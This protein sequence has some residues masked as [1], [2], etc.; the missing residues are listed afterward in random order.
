MTTRPS[1]MSSSGREPRNQ[2]VGGDSETLDRADEATATAEAT[3]AV[4]LR[5]P[6]RQDGSVMWRVARE[7]GVLEEN[8]EYV[9]N[10]FCHF[11]ARACVV[12]EVDG[13][14]AGFIAGLFPPEQPDTVFVWQI[15]VDERFRGRRIARL[16]LAELLRRN[17]PEIRFLEATVTPSNE[18]SRNAFEGFA[19]SCGSECV[20]SVLFPA[21][22]FA[23]PADEDEVLFRIG[24]IDPD[25]EFL[26]AAEE[27]GARTFSR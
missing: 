20:Q 4:M 26:R 12:A 24:P 27:G 10:M 14:P 2:G 21:Q 23:G 25:S 3:P 9:Y 11:F 16:M 1:H 8:S 7:S 5:Q 13:E 18:A 15:A 19:R 17:G 6:T 22:D